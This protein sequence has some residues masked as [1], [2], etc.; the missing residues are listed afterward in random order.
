MNA[1]V[2]AELSGK[3]RNMGMEEQNYEQSINGFRYNKYVS[4]SP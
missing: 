4:S 3:Q 2:T 1:A